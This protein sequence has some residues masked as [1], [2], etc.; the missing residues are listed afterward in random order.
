MQ[1]SGRTQREVADDLGIGLSTLVRWVGR[2]RD[3]LIDE[4]AK[5]GSE[6]VLAE[7]KRLRR[8]NEI[9]RQEREILKRAA[10][11]FR[12]G[13]KSMRFSFIDA[14]KAEFP[15][16]ACAKCLASARAGSMP[17]RID[18][19]KDRR[20]EG[21]TGLFQAASGHGSTRPC[22]IGVQTLEWHLWEPAHDAG[23]AG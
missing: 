6:D 19:W 21:S 8:E 10:A 7:L 5:P 18:A 16:T 13:G 14:K 20:L 17:G 22:S 1:A 23:V 2:S 9:L 3:R 12:Q 11:F 4:P 15:S